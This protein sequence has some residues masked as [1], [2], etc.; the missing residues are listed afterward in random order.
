MHVEDIVQIDTA[1]TALESG[2]VA[3]ALEELGYVH[4]MIVGKHLSEQAFNR[5]F[6]AMIA[7]PLYWAGKRDVAQRNV[8]VHGIYSGLRD[9]TMTLP[10]AIALLSVIRDQ[11]L[12][13]ALRTDL[14]AL[15]HAWQSAADIFPT[16]S[17][18][19]SRAP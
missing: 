16:P 3:W 15:E 18:R 11:E 6:E 2:Q 4:G 10:D 5:N 8:N 1:L 7:E 14:E 19:S 13:D 12:V 17:P 9:G